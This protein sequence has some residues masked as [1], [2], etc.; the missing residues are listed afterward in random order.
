L[1]PK[2]YKSIFL[3]NVKSTPNYSKTLISAGIDT[4]TLCQPTTLFAT[5]KIQL[6]DSTKVKS[7]KATTHTTMDSG[8]PGHRVWAEAIL[9][10]LARSHTLV[11]GPGHSSIS[12]VPGPAA[13]P[14]VQQENILKKPKQNNFFHLNFFHCVVMQISC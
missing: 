11:A 4:F 12:L 8:V 2:F 10:Q 7:L 3:W 9:L 5:K 1:H 14:N 6:K 13:W